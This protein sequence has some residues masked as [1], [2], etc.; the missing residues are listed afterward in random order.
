MSRNDFWKTHPGPLLWISFPV[1]GPA[2]NPILYKNLI[3]THE[4]RV[5]EFSRNWHDQKT[6]I[7]EKIG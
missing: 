1:I 4:I 2:H 6:E 3:S 7:L 5:Y